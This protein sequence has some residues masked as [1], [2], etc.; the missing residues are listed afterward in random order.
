MKILTTNLLVNVLDEY[1]YNKYN[2]RLGLNAHL[3]IGLQFVIVYTNNHQYTITYKS[4][5][6]Y[7]VEN[8]TTGTYK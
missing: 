1:L 2:I 4:L 8:Q 6:K 5:Y 3:V 7:Y